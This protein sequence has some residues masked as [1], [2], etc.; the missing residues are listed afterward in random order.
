[1]IGWASY[2]EHF[3]PPP[4]TRSPVQDVQDSY[5]LGIPSSTTRGVEQRGSVASENIAT[6]PIVDNANR[7]G[8]QVP[9][10]MSL[11]PMSVSGVSTPVRSPQDQVGLMKCMYGMFGGARSSCDT[12]DFHPNMITRSRRCSTSTLRQRSFRSRARRLSHLKHRGNFGKLPGSASFKQTRA[13]GSRCLD[14]TC[15]AL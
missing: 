12:T 6:A 9:Q 10:R 8:Q 7:L 5:L 4:Q 14:F 1:M 15:L 2:R 11:P 13:C 3:G